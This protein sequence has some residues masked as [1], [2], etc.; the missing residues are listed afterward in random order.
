MKAREMSG[1]EHRLEE[2][3]R[4][5]VSKSLFLAQKFTK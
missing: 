4:E 5:N 1:E 3:C 2:Q